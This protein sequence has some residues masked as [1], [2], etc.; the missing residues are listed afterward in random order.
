MCICLKRLY[1][2]EGQLTILTETI[3]NED[4]TAAVHETI[5]NKLED[6]H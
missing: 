1:K 5:T 3:P 4:T 2:P 6:I